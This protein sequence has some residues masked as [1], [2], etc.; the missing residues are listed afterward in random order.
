MDFSAYKGFQEDFERRFGAYSRTHPFTMML[1]DLEL[2]NA[3]FGDAAIAQRNL[4]RQTDKM[5][6][7]DLLM[8][9]AARRSASGP[10][11]YIEM[12]GFNDLA[13]GLS[14]RFEARGFRIFSRRKILGTPANKFLHR[15]SKLGP[16]HSAAMAR[17]GAEGPEAILRDRELLDRL[18]STLVE[19]YQRMKAFV[20]AQDI[21]V[22]VA[23]GDAKPFSRFLCRI[24]QE[25][26][27]PYVV[28]AHGYVSH[29][30]LVSI[31]PLHADRL[32]AWTERQ[33]ELLRVAL[34]DRGPDIRCFGFPVRSA[35]PDRIRVERRVLLAWEPL[36]RP[37]KDASHMP[38]L[39]QLAR[40]CAQAGYTAVLR[41]HPKERKD[42]RIARQ[43]QDMGLVLDDDDMA[44]ALSR[45]A[46]VVSSNSTVLCEAAAFGVP[47]VQIT[48]LSEFEFEGA[49]QVAVAEFDPARAAASESGQPA[50][51][52]MDVDMLFSDISDLMQKSEMKGAS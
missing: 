7:A 37:G 14:E 10:Q 32:I 24:A 33:A 42:A 48:E 15:L 9:V 49:D 26:G 46:V 5:W 11:V 25:L 20:S 31:A 28:V 50:F 17:G 40:I 6:L 22:F 38:V 21:R 45:A 13:A 2:R 34:P 23:S 19:N 3:L 4:A 27:L 29:T 51:P 12:P 1:L 39:G 8:K 36:S 44:T 43:V 16:S 41:L 47:A 52:L 18:E 35:P 30:T